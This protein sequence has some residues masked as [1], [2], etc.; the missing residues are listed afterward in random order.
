MTGDQAAEAGQ[1]M[2]KS[3][4][5]QRDH[6]AQ[7]FLEQRQAVLDE[8]TSKQNEFAPDPAAPQTAAPAEPTYTRAEIEAAMR[9]L[10]IEQKPTATPPPNP[11]PN[12]SADQSFVM[13]EI[14]FTLRQI[15]AAEVRRQ[16]VASGIP[17]PTRS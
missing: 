16:L 17:V 14:A 2:L 5:E 9:A 12:P 10:Q 11:P 3:A 13:Q 15:I 4:R 6:I 7:G 1:E 8:V